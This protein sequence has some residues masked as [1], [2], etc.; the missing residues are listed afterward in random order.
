M[1]LVMAMEL[2]SNMK[3]ATRVHPASTTDLSKRAHGALL[4]QP[5]KNFFNPKISVSLGSVSG[6][7][8]NHFKMQRQHH[9]QINTAVQS[10]LLCPKCT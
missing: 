1:P 9:Q 3:T 7:H 10:L 8:F 4:R 6:G 2:P 5:F